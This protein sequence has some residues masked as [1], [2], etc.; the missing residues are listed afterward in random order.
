MNIP[1]YSNL[2]IQIVRETSVRESDCL[3]NVRYPYEIS[4]EPLNGFA[5]NSHGRGLLSFARTDEFEGQ[6]SR[7]PGT[8]TNE[9]FGRFDGLRAF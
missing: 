5:L 7:S 6:R 1:K 4:R 3:G 8:E 9:I 2:F